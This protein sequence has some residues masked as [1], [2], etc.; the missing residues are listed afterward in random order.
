MAVQGYTD[1]ELERVCARARELCR[2]VGESSQRAQALVGLATYYLVRAELDTASEVGR[3]LLDLG[4]HTGTPLAVIGAHVLLGWPSLYRGEPQTAL[5]HANQALAVYDPQRHRA[6]ADFSQTQDGGVVSRLISGW[7]RWLLGQPDQG[8]EQTRA[9][10]ELAREIRHPFSLVFALAYCAS[11]HQMRRER[12]S[13]LELAEELIRVSAQQAFP[14]WLGWGEV[15][16]GWALADAEQAEGIEL[17]RRGLDR[18]AATGAVV[19]GPF[20]LALLADAHYRNGHMQDALR[21]L[22]TGFALSRKGRQ[23][24]WDAELHRMRGEILLSWKG[25]TAGAERALRDALEVARSQQAR[26]LELR[27][28][29]SMARLLIQQDRPDRAHALLHPIYRSF[30]EGFEIHD[31]REARRLL[32]AHA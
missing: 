4:V 32:D 10:V 20:V 28:A 22:D 7:A 31:L 15:L 14:V 12:E 18:V 19:S 21:T 29:S 23:R 6:L 11:M 3:E 5:R 16:R 24:F 13:V 9:G 8:L 2:D 26:L 25:D 27:A 17:A 1:P 30:S